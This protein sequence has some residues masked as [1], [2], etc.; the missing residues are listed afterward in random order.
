MARAARLLPACQAGGGGEQAVWPQL[1]LCW[2]V[3]REMQ[4]PERRRGGDLRAP[5]HLSGWVAASHSQVRT[6]PWPSLQWRGEFSFWRCLQ[7]PCTWQLG[8]RS[9]GK[10]WYSVPGCV[11]LS[12]FHLCLKQSRRAAKTGGRAHLV[13]QRDRGKWESVSLDH[14]FRNLQGFKT[15]FFA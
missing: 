3:S 6:A 12:L 4:G 2:G 11:K 13:E 1:R 10:L 15:S 8:Q 14:V 9:C 5:C 7:Q